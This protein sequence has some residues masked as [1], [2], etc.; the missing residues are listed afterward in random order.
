MMLRLKE[1]QIACITYHKHP[2][3]VWP[4]EEFSHYRVAL[5][6]GEEVMMLLAERGI[7]L[8]NKLWLREIRKLNDNEH[9]TFI[10]TTHYL[11]DI[12][13]IAS[14]MFARWSQ[15]NFF[16]YMRMNY[17]IDALADYCLDDIP[18]TTQVVNPAYRKLDS[19]IRSLNGK[20][21]RRLG[22][23]GEIN[24]SSW[25]LL[26]VKPI[27]SLKKLMLLKIKRQH[28][29]MKLPYLKRILTP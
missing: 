25:S 29:L 20:L 23:F 16:R 10:I 28:F 18:D 26:L 17:N 12:K 3:E 21:S 5:V 27:L 1:K 4:R 11:M 24:L 2:D 8:G 9:Q 7:W 13:K 19:Q 22:Q 6:T 14:S 15:E